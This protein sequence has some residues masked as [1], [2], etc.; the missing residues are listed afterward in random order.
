MAAVAAA[1]TPMTVTAFGRVASTATH[2]SCSPED[3]AWCQIS[4]IV[5][6]DRLD[7]N[8]NAQVTGR[9]LR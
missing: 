9:Q 3:A 5:R 6:P 8:N 1:E 2:T 4:Q 7:R